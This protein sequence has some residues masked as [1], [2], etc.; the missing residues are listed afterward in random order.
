[1]SAA[2]ATAASGA[3]GLSTA[4]IRRELLARTRIISRARQ[5]TARR[6]LADDR[7]RHSTI[8]TASAIVLQAGR[9]GLRAA[10]PRPGRQQQLQ[11]RSPAAAAA[12]MVAAV[13]A[14]A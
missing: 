11:A 5:L 2:A 7:R 1:V 3:G 14:A 4:E 6:P 13:A 8:N 12:A 10:G 9:L